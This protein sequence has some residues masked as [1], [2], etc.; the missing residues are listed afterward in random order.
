VE[1]VSN[2]EGGELD[3]KLADY[4][5]MK[6]DYYVVF[7]PQR[8]LVPETLRVYALHAGHFQIQ[9]NAWLEN[10]GLGLCLWKGVFE[11]R[12]DTWL[13]WCDEYEAVIPTGA[14][15]AEAERKN[16]EAERKNVEAER[17]RADAEHA[18]AERLLARLREL[19][20]D[21]SGT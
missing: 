13:R 8:R 12:D 19:G 5:Q 10:V 17:R 21:V 15:R 14:E 1:I 9:P 6:V 2:R 4:A 16:V 3:R 7:D 20:E 18:R 11:G